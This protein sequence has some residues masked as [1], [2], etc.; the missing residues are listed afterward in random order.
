MRKM[1]ESDHVPFKTA[2]TA[3][4]AVGGGGLEVGS[5]RPIA[6]TAL[7]R[8][9]PLNSRRLT[10]GLLR[11]LAS[12]L[13]V[14]ETTAHSDLLTLIEGKLRDSEHDPLHTGGPAGGGKR[15]TD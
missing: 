4:G 3:I 1:A 6:R 9:M 11:Q 14:P 15:Y 13:G 10:G 8:I 7:R 2:E 5:D 12:G